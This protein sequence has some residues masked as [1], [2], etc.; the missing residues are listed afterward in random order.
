MPWFCIRKAKIDTELRNTFERYGVVA[1]Q[2]VLATTNYFVHQGK[3]LN[4]EGAGEPLLA[5]LT[6]QYDKADRKETWSLA[7]EGTITVFVVLGVVVEGWQLL[8]NFGWLHVGCLHC[9]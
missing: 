3:Q 2:V 1:A 5:W 6:E 9:P 4:A 8:C 7:M